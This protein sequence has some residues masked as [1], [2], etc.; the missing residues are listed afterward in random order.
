MLFSSHAGES[1]HSHGFKSREDMDQTIDEK[2]S[3]IAKYE[4]RIQGLKELKTT[5]EAKLK[6]NPE[7][8]IKVAH[9]DIVQKV[10]ICTSRSSSA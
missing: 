7:D 6:R 5:L 4:V 2:E 3:V 1:E 9:E 8:Q 10:G